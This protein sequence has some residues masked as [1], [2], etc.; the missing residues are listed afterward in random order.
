MR[1]FV[2]CGSVGVCAVLLALAGCGKDSESSSSSSS[3]GGSK[4]AVS[5]WQ[6]PSGIEPLEVSAEPAGEPT[7]FR[8]GRGADRVVEPEAVQVQLETLYDKPVAPAETDVTVRAG[9]AEV[10]IAPGTI[11]EPQ[12]LVIAKA[13]APAALPV[14]G[15]DAVASWKV[16]LGDSHV[17][18]RPLTLRFQLPA[19][20]A[21]KAKQKRQPIA[22]MH[23]NPAARA[24]VYTPVAFDAETGRASIR[25]R[26]LTLFTIV[27]RPVNNLIHDT[28]YT[29]HFAIFYTKKDILA[30]TEISEEQ[31]AK[32]L[33]AEVDGQTGATDAMGMA[34]QVDDQTIEV[35]GRTDVPMYIVYLAKALEYGWHRYKGQGLDV[36]EYTRT[37][38]YV[39][40]N[41]PLSDENH[42]GK[43]L[44]T[45]EIT[46]S[47]TWRPASM[48]V[49]TAHEFFHAVQA[50]YLGLAVM[51]MNYR[52]WWLEALAEFAPKTVWGDTVSQKGMKA[53]FLKLPLP[54]MDDSHEY[55]CSHLVRFLVNKKG[56]GFRELTEGTLD[57]PAGIL[58]MEEA[59]APD[60]AVFNKLLGFD[61][62]FED[63]TAAAT[64]GM[65]DRFLRQR[66]STLADAYAEFAA[67]AL[68]DAGCRALVPDGTELLR[69]AA[70][71]H[72]PGGLALNDEKIE[73]TLETLPHGTADIWAVSV[74]NPVAEASADRP[75]RK[76]TVEVDGEVPALTR[77]E[78]FVLKDQQ[79]P[80]GGLKPAASLKG[81]NPTADVA[82]GAKDMLYI[83]STN[84]AY[85]PA[86]VTVRVL[87]GLDF[88]I[89]PAEVDTLEPKQEV[90]FRAV[91][92]SLPKTLLPSRLEV[93]W[94]PVSGTRETTAVRARGAGFESKYEYAWL[95]KGDYVLLAELLDDGKRIATAKVAVKVAPANEPS[96]T[97]E[98][99]SITVPAGKEFSISAA[100][101]NAPK[102]ATYQWKV[103][104]NKAI[105]T[106]SPQCRFTLPSA[107]EARLKVK[108]IDGDRGVV[109]SDTCSLTVEPGTDLVWIED[110]TTR[111]GEK[112]L[113]RRYQVFRGT[114]T[115]HGQWLEYYCDGKH[116]GTLE[117]RKTFDH[118]VCLKSESFYPDGSPKQIEH[119]NKEGKRHGE[120]S[121]YFSDGRRALL[122][123]YSNGVKNGPYEMLY[124]HTN[125]YV[126]H[127]GRYLD[128]KI[129]G[130]LNLYSGNIKSGREYL[131]KSQEHAEGKRHG[132]QVE[133]LSDGRK[134]Y[135]GQYRNG[136][137][138]GWAKSWY[139]SAMDEKY[140]LMSETLYED[141]KAVQRRKYNSDGEVVSDKKIQR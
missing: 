89:E 88:R 51:S 119:F 103:N 62:P 31:W 2:M 26:H 38:I 101:A 126:R 114:Y 9:D 132:K 15:L 128:G 125:T 135:E 123:T 115:K 17:F 95:F 48:R 45:I 24:W 71:H 118:N 78:A 66:G 139:H 127:N 6:P 11:Q 1:R 58:A 129:H 56:I 47:S 43:L 75:P 54:T 83:V 85:K 102:G 124:A 25:T 63:Y 14:E 105:E 23:Y 57:V 86:A 109:A 10:V 68:F 100:V 110:H 73:Q 137:P 79:R 97:L 82:V 32:K 41:S 40:V 49:A 64:C 4:G 104:Y 13:K 91:S 111:N 90:A 35:E 33:V 3:S 67:W 99:R 70:G 28:V 53:N 69:L 65:I 42:R 133:Y 55:G 29:D 112:L 39:G 36:P 50:E 80:A 120:R 18:A 138:D 5:A 44:G 77:L 19:E 74:E 141:G 122:E 52:G 117:N 134:S 21:E 108:M 27:L 87:G 131:W 16:A 92:D 20:V 12:T 107:G 81:S 8:R 96:I 59:S 130:Q 7:W 136:K 37:D 116:D 113:R 61:A 72:T 98:A 106:R 34:R 30:D 140:Y 60:F 121:A 93:R 94:T 76:V 22:A 84:A 46:P